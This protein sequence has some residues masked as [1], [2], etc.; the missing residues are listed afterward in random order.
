MI[1][2]Q[3]ILSSCLLFSL[4][5]CGTVA[6][7]DKMGALADQY[8]ALAA[9][10]SELKVE[11]TTAVTALDEL[12]RDNASGARSAFGDLSAAVAAIGPQLSELKQA[13]GTAQ[14]A[15]KSHFETWAAQNATITDEKLKARANERHGDVSGSL[16][17]L[18]E[19]SQKSFA[20][21][22]G[23]AAALQ[24]LQKYLTNDLSPAAVGGAADLIARTRADGDR[25]AVALDALALDVARYAGKLGA[26]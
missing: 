3:P 19:Q 8:G 21:A 18:D 7:H 2:R 10:V 20:L 25:L 14:L 17:S 12:P 4:A 23:F 11:V 5:A 15:A 22:D 26:R 1:L 9:S 16:K 6:G 24:D 13:T